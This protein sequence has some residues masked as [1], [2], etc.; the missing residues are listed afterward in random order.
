MVAFQE[1]LS[2]ASNS[3]ESS[4]QLFFW[5]SLRKSMDLYAEL[6]SVPD[7]NGHLTGALVHTLHIALRSNRTQLTRL[8]KK[9]DYDQNSFHNEMN[10]FIKDSLRV[11]TDDL[12]SNV[13]L[14]DENGAMHLL[15]ALKELK[16]NNE[17]ISVWSSSMDLPALKFTFLQPKVVGVLLPMMY[18]LGSSYAD[19]ENLFN[20]SN[21]LDKRSTHPFLL[22]GMIK[23][24]LAAEEYEKALK[25]YNELCDHPTKSLTIGTLVD[26]HLAFIGECKNIEIANSF[27]ERAIDREMPYKLTIQVNNVKE[28]LS[29]IWA[30]TQDF[31]RV[32]DVW[33]KAT[34]FYGRNINHGVSSSL[35]NRFFEIFFENYPRATVESLNKL[36]EIISVYNDMKPIDEPFFNIII[37]KVGIWGDKSI[38]SSLY[39]AYEIYNLKKTQVSRRIYLKSLGSVEVSSQ[40][41]ITAWNDLVACSDAEGYNYIANADWAALRDATI[42]ASGFDRNELYVKIWKQYQ[43]FCRDQNQ[44]QRISN[45]GNLFTQIQ[46]LLA[47]LNA[48][49]ASEIV[50]PAFENL[51]YQNFN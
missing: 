36:K 45:N 2:D 9:P 40:E 1:C 5:E 33:Q 17:A 50:V 48:I 6:K 31:N 11:I 41:I 43:Y 22:G 28:F 26:V 23:A 25:Y 44:F 13:V 16:L 51:R 3:T 29:N 47:N 39:E 8:A 4:G 37:S 30:E 38:I 15:T 34:K 35:N 12:L 21:S 27:F 42:A 7:F 24:S 14:I 46:P 49:D 10:Q 19:L 18:Q 20:Q 32:V